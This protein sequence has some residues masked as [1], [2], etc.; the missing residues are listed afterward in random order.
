MTSSAG[1]LVQVRLRVA[2]DVFGD[3]HALFTTICSVKVRTMN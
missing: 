3:Y 2:S 1:K